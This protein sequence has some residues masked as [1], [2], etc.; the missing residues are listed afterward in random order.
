MLPDWTLLSEPLQLALSREAM[1]RAVDIVAEQA[2]AL[3]GEIRMGSIADRGGADALR[4][5][6]SVIRVTSRDPLVPAGCG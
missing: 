5:F 3:A 6:A 4:L 1:R 2:E